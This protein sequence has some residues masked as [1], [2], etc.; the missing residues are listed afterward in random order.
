V[1]VSH[2]PHDSSVDFNSRHSRVRPKSATVARSPVAFPDER[3]IAN[4]GNRV[5]PAFFVEP[6]KTFSLTDLIDLAES[7]NPETRIAWENARA[8]AAALG[9]ARSELYPTL[10]AVALSGVNREEVPLGS[11]F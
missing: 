8:Q 1:R 2:A 9:I 11:Q 10:S 7:H 3:Q 6:D 4:E 5:R